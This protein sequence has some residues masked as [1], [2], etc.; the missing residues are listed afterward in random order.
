MILAAECGGRLLLKSQSAGI[1]Q[2]DYWLLGQIVFFFVLR[3][4]S[5]SAVSEGTFQLEG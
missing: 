2:A 4:K 5:I 3:E 1:H